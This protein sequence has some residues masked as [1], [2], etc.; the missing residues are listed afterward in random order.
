MGQH[1]GLLCC[2]LST[3]TNRILLYDRLWWGLR[4]VPLLPVLWAQILN[5]HPHESFPWLR[6]LPQEGSCLCCPVW[7]FWVQSWQCWVKRQLQISEQ[8][9]E[10]SQVHYLRFL[11]ATIKIARSLYHFTL[12]WLTWWNMKPCCG[13]W[14]C[15]TVCLSQTW[16]R[17]T[18]TIL[19]N[20]ARRGE[21]TSCALFSG[22]STTTSWA[23]VHSAWSAAG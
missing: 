15:L 4:S 20:N 1:Q 5:S 23:I 8:S 10:I 6:L 7:S 22:S 14:F 16:L 2:C 21:V 3:L 18:I 9:S 11:V 19:I 17:V 13:S 12:P